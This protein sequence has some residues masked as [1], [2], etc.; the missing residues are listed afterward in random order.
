VRIHGGRPD[1]VEA[2]GTLLHV[3]S[4]TVGPVHPRLHTNRKEPFNHLK[5]E[6]LQKEKKY[7]TSQVMRLEVAI[8]QWNELES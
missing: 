6:L 4:V 8:L 1:D 2:L 7:S 5:T 3:T